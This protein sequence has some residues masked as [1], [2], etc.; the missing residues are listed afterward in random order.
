MKKLP[1]NFASLTK[2]VLGSKFE[3]ATKYKL[4]WIIKMR[5][6]TQTFRVSIGSP[7]TAEY[8]ERRKTAAL[9]SFTTKTETQ[10]KSLRTSFI[11]TAE[12]ERNIWF[13]FL[14]REYRTKSGIIVCC[15]KRRHKL[16]YFSLPCISEFW[17]TTGT[18][19]DRDRGCC[20]RRKLF[21]FAHFWPAEIEHSFI[22][23]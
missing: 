9:R 10:K 8:R 17:R 21:G 4:F 18:F 19:P 5:D 23:K 16:T 11:T 2:Y 3:S 7:I 20:G 15:V 13:A 12:V 22:G 1:K 6:G 14:I